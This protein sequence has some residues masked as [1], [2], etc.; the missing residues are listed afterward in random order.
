LGEII[1]Q[2]F[3]INYRM[4]LLAYHIRL[5]L[6]YYQTLTTNLIWYYHHWFSK[7]VSNEQVSLDEL[8]DAASNAVLEPQTKVTS[9]AHQTSA[10]LRQSTVIGSYQSLGMGLQN[11][12]D[13]DALSMYHSVYG[14]AVSEL[15]QKRSFLDDLADVA[16]QASESEYGLEDLA[17]AAEF[18]DLTPEDSAS[19]H[20]RIDSSGEYRLDT[21]ADQT[22][23]AKLLVMFSAVS[24]SA[25]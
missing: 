11:R 25:V 3:E 13:V 10:I 2:T 23:A 15:S 16:D 9:T 7:R 19:K 5:G 18:L 17:D 22:D 4:S 14:T 12:K 8:A 1:V 24:V 6:W 20:S 21:R